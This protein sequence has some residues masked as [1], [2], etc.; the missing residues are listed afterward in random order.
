MQ[1]FPP[2]FTASCADC[3]TSRTVKYVAHCSGVGFQPMV[4][5]CRD[6]DRYSDRISRSEA[7]FVLD[8]EDRSALA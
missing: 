2:S 4:A 5:V 7:S 3:S 8:A 1:I 6:I